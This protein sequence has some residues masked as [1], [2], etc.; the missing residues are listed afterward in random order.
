MSLDL[1]QLQNEL[2]RVSSDGNAMSNLFVRMPE[3]AGVV[4]LRILGPA[5]TGM[6][7]RPKSGLFQSTRIHKVNGRSVHCPKELVGNK[8]KGKCKIC[9]YY[10]HLWETS[11]KS[12]PDVAAKLQAFAREIKPI[13][14]YYYNVIVRKE[15]NPQTNET[16]ENVGP[17]ILS[18]GK[19]V[20]KMILRAILGDP[21]LEEEPLGDITD[22]ITGRDFKLIKTIK[23]SGQDSFPDYATSKFL[24]PS[25]L[26]E[27]DQVQEWLTNLHDL[28]TLRIVREPDYIE[29]QLKVHLGMEQE[30]KGDDDTGFNPDE[31]KLP[32]DE[33]SGEEATATVTQVTVP[34]MPKTEATSEAE[35]AEPETTQPVEQSVAVD[36]TDFDDIVKG[37]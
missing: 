4:L 16:L 26:G 20:H 25:V 28:A 29:H 19:T 10:N 33:D 37:L 1:Q 17:K 27:P 5:A 21:E 9:D 31:W 13:E 6:F 22:P 3:G 12:A 18:V 7:D 34:D 35:A 24:D 15:F 32:T 2:E 8:W 14:R 23:K 36:A 11:K 30:E